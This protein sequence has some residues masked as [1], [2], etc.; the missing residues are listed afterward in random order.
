MVKKEKAESSD[1]EAEAK[2][3]KKSFKEKLNLQSD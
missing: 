1:S 2:P 3:A